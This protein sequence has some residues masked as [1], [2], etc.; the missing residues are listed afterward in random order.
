MISLACA[1]LLCSRAVFLKFH[2]GLETDAGGGRPETWNTSWNGLIINEKLNGDIHIGIA[3][4][5]KTSLD[6]GMHSNVHI[7]H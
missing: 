4:K 1:L 6:T 7:C 2:D 3:E 5:L